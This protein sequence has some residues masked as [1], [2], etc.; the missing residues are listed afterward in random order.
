MAKFETSQESAKY[1]SEIIRAV[2][3]PRIFSEQED[4]HPKQAPP[5]YIVGTYGAQV[6]S[7]DR[8]ARSGKFTGSDLSPQGQF[9]LLVNSGYT[10]SR[11]E[12]IDEA[13]AR[14]GKKPPE[15]SDAF[16]RASM[17]AQTAGALACGTRFTDQKKK[18]EM[19]GISVEDGLVVTFN[20]A[21]I[22]TIE[23]PQLEFDA[24]NED[25]ELVLPKSPPLD[26]ISAIYPIGKNASEMLKQKLDELSREKYICQ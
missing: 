16:E 15:H 18:S 13:Y 17:Y 2:K 22:I 3:P 6:E 24:T 4:N 19:E 10:G 9:H 7:I 21:A 14:D 23:H 26:A 12:V 25:L 1:L 20:Q 11:R 5:F 8:L